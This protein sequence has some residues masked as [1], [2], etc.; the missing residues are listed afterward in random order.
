VKGTVLSL[1]NGWPGNKNYYHWM[2]A[3]L[4]RIHLVHQAG[5]LGEVDFYLIPDDSFPFQ[6]ETLDLLGIPREARISS[7]ETPHLRADA[8]I[9]TTHPRPKPDNG[10]GWIV[11]WIR[12]AFQKHSSDREYSRFVYVGRGDAGRRRLL[13]EEECFSEVLQPLGFE[14]YE[15]S[16]MSLPSQIR[17]FAGADVIVGIHGAALTNLTFCKRATS[18]IELFASP[19]RLRMFE[20]LCNLRGLRYCA[21]VS[22]NYTT[23]VP[24]VDADFTVSL[25]DLTATLKHAEG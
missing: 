23:D 14:A 15:L 21:I 18:V 1:L 4:P 8:V 24:A 7:K 17:L 3:I 19:W 13:N 2:T 10:P 16:E 6:I 9:A 11:E 20:N 5:L 25:D 22:Q 12:A